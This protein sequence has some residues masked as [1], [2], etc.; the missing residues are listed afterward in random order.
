MGNSQFDEDGIRRKIEQ[1]YKQR[2]GLMI[3]LAA[4]AISN[5]AFWG[6]WLLLAPA[7]VT[8]IAPGGVETTTPMSLGFPW[9]IFITLGWG[10]GIVAHFLTYYY[11]YG[12]GSNR[13]E[14]AIQREVEQELARREEAGYLEKPKNEQRMR[15]TEDG[16]LEAVSDDSRTDKSKRG[17]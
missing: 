15:L 11:R 5:V 10:V 12:G 7:G 8:A 13:R 14:E 2:M 9:P 16:E 17:Q 6:M 4:F 3:H 1:R